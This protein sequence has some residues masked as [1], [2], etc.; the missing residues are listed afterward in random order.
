MTLAGAA[1]ERTVALDTT[2]VSV[3]LAWHRHR[4]EERLAAGATPASTKADTAPVPLPR[5]M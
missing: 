2:A 1:E 4:E 5:R 3:L